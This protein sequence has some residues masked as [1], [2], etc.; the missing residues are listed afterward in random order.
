[1]RALSLFWVVLLISVSWAPFA[2]AAPGGAS[3]EELVVDG[4]K[5]AWMDRSVEALKR[6]KFEKIDVN[7]RKSE[8]TAA[9]SSFT[10]GGSITLGFAQEESKTRIKIQTTG[11]LDNFYSIFTSPSD[12]IMEKFKKA[13]AEERRAAQ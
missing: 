7:V 5:R 13:F 4:Y 1:M 8:V 6:A 11:A 2:H 3:S 10:I 9:Y 12:R